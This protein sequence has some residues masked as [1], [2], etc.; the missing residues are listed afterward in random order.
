MRDS[1]EE[2]RLNTA[3]TP[4]LYVGLTTKYRRKRKTVVTTISPRLASNN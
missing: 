1:T 3:L 4:I 2:S